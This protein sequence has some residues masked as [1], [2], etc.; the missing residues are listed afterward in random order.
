MEIIPDKKQQESKNVSVIGYVQRNNVLFTATNVYRVGGRALY[1]STW[2]EMREKK[3]FYL[4]WIVIILMLLTLMSIMKSS[5]KQKWTS[6]T[7]IEIA[8]TYNVNGDYN[9]TSNEQNE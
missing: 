7:K 4:T 8:D 5:K 2:L 3:I 9:L 1:K 6:I